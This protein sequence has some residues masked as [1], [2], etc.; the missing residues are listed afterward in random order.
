MIK[1]ITSTASQGGMRKRQLGVVFSLL[2]DAKLVA[3]SGATLTVTF[4]SEEICR[5]IVLEPELEP[6]I[7]A[8]V[9]EHSGVTL[10]WRAFRKALE[11][12]GADLERSLGANL[13]TGF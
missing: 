1:T 13:K 6:A 9:N 7:V 4:S 12:R 3:P 10:G 5:T 8:V 2:G 11:A